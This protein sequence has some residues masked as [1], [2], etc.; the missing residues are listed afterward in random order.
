LRHRDRLNA[1]HV[2]RGVLGVGRDNDA[3]RQTE[4]EADRLGVY[5]MER[6]GYDPAAAVRF[7]S[8]YGPHPLNFLRSRD[9][10]AWQERVRLMNVEIA[11]IRAARAAGRTPVP[12]FVTLPLTA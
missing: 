10:P 2:S 7:W 11:K 9:H 12:D 5:L 8:R 4:I 6:A 1:A 3:I